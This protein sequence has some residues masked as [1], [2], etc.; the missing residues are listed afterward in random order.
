MGKI[1]NKRELAQILG[2][3]ERTLTEWQRLGMPMVVDAGRGSANQYDTVEVIRWLVAREAH[4]AG[5]ESV[6]DRLDRLRGDQIERQMAIE[7]RQ[8]VPSEEVA[9]AVGQF[10][11]DAVAL[12]MS[13]PDK[14]AP[15]LSEVGEPEA[16][17][18]IMV[19]MIEELRTQLGN[20]EFRED[21]SDESVA[22]ADASAAQ[23]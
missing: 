2:T 11:T 9:P 13:L 15:L 1:V 4:G 16:M 20:Y 22:E 17:H 5:K 21:F 23:D 3:S 10:I 8:L 12:M 19:D 14:Y 7:A 6:K 18:A